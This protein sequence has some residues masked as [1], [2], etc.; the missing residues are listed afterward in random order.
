[1]TNQPFLDRLAQHLWDNYIKD[2]REL[3]VVLPSKRSRVFLLKSLQKVADKVVFSPKII[4]IENFIEEISRIKTLE[5][6]D[7]LLQL[8]QTYIS[9]VPESQKE[10]FES[11]SK[12]AGTLLNDFNEIDRYFIEPNKVFSYLKEIDALKRWNLEPNET[13]HLIK[14]YLQFWDLIPKLYKTFYE[15]L[16]S[17][18]LGYQGIVYREAVNQLSNYI[19][20]NNNQKFVFAGF[21]A[22]NKAEETIFQKLQSTG[23]AEVIWDADPFFL[24]DP[25]HDAGLFLRKHKSEW[26]HYKTHP[27]DWMNQCFSFDKKIH[28]IGTPKSVGQ[29]RIAGDIVDE[30]MK[31]NVNLER[32][33]LVLGDENLLIPVLHSLPSEL[34]SMN[35]TMSFSGKSNPVQI[36]IHKIFKMQ[37]NAQK[38]NRSNAIFYHKDVLEVLSH[39]LLN[40]FFNSMQ[41]VNHLKKN[42]I[43][44]LTFSKLYELQEFK[45]DMFNFIFKPWEGSA[46]EVLQNINGIL[47]AIRKYLKE[48]K[49]QKV[50]IAFVYSLYVSIQKLLIYANEHQKVLNL[51]TLYELFRE[52]TENAD[53]SFEGEPLEGLQ[54]MGILESRVLDF[55]NVIITSVNEG[56]FPA[57]KS[58]QTFIPHDVKRELGLP[59]FK[60]KD[61]VYTYHFYNLI[62][63]AKNVFL[64]YNTESEGLEQGEKS[65]FIT[66]LEVESL[67]NHE[68]IQTTYAAKVPGLLNEPKTIEKTP[69]FLVRVNEIAQTGFSPS[70]LATYIRNPLQFYYQRVL[71]IHGVEEVEEQIAANTLGSV[72]HET[73]EEL[74][75]PYLKTPLKLEHLQKMTEMLEVLLKQSFAS[76]YKD[77]TIFKGKNLLAYEVTKKYLQKFIEHEMQKLGSNDIIIEGLEQELRVEIIHNQLPFPVVL[78]GNLDR[79]DLINNRLRIIDYK[80]G[81]VDKAQ[82]KFNGFDELLIETKKD[83]IFQLLCYV[84]MLYKQYNIIPEEACIYSF[85]NASQGMMPIFDGKVPLLITPELLDDFEAILVTLIKEILNPQIPIVEKPP[86]KRY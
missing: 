62:K 68:L 80:T 86:E 8:Y 61:A 56:T 11:F 12:W 59:T 47:L 27:F 72:I 49:E 83:K 20:T 30:L 41:L 67:P 77:G 14:N 57:G 6:P 69:K 36:L 81:K 82:L 42:N 38:R 46:P 7:V 71:K 5:K 10:D 22:L 9:I 55:E 23:L 58:P 66:Q 84:Y 51:K 85:K 53:V 79:I 18:S 16:T 64:I 44:F 37:L 63:R 4:S 45:D 75:K 17:K 19:A 60:E 65:R 25:Y 52:T 33:A 35:I 78:K 29:A 24:N 15:H 21:N 3:T 50:T 26:P 40:S 32:T 1:M 28:I 76:I 34:P 2:N 13:T 74:Y 73:L 54:I 31:V 70:S 43:S 48:E 39:P